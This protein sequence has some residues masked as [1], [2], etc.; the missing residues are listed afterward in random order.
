M[1]TTSSNGRKS[2]VSWSVEVSSPKR[3][4]GRPSSAQTS[5]GKRPRGRPPKKR[6]IDDDSGGEKPLDK[7][8]SPRRRRVRARKVKTKT[9]EDEERTKYMKGIKREIRQRFGEIGFGIWGRRRKDS[10]YNWLPVLEIGP[11]DL[12]EGPV[13]QQWKNYYKAVSTTM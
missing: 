6:K 4:R 2:S 13:R 11:Y 8:E 12:A 5:S 7:S 9:L 10:Y 1:T 3:K